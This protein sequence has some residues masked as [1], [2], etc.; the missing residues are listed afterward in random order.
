MS[1]KYI[2][3]INISMGK[4]LI[5]KRLVYVTTWVAWQGKSARAFDTL[6]QVS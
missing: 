1:N 5:Q 6:S 4:K 2:Y 3:I